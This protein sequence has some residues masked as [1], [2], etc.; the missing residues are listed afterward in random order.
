MSGENTECLCCCNKF[1]KTTRSS[2]KC[3]FGECNFEACKECVRKYLL[4]SNSE[5][6]CMSCRKIWSQRFLI[7]NLNRSFVTGIYK[8]HLQNI[9][10]EKRIARLPEYMTAAENYKLCKIQENIINENKEKIQELKN[11]MQELEYLNSQCYRKINKI[12]TGNSEMSERKKFIMPC[13]NQSCRGFLSTKYKCGICQLY[14][15]PHC[16]EI[17]GDSLE[18]EH[19]CNEDSVKNAEFIK[20]STKPCPKCGVRV[21]KSSG[22]SQ[23]YCVE[24]GCNTAWNWNTGKIDLGIVHNPHFFEMQRKNQINNVATVLAP[25]CG[26]NLIHNFVLNLHIVKKIKANIPNNES[27]SKFLISMIEEIYRIIAHIIHDTV[28]QYRQKIDNFNTHQE[29]Y[30]IQYIIGS[31]NKDKY[32]QITYTTNIMKKKYTEIIH[33]YDLLTTLGIELFNSLASSNEVL[34]KF[35]D[36]V[37]ERILDF[38]KIRIYTNEQLQEISKTY[39]NVVYQISPEWKF[40]KGKFGMKNKKSE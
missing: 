28:I 21:Q 27:E 20:S 38:D 12:K 19:V 6:H 40:S 17:I 2:I 14:T 11:Q 9:L 18:I 32:S 23:M 25:N 3:E 1:N 39:N 37:K 36:E 35:N 33:I 4:G 26:N 13:P 30:A 10:V 8:E 15:C 29:E 31:Y 5:A 16:V 24:P 22:C 7:R 34:N